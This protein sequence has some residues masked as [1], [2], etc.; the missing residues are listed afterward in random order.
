MFLPALF[1]WT[2]VMLQ[3]SKVQK[4]HTLL[5]TISIPGLKKLVHGMPWVQGEF[6]VVFAGTI[7]SE[8]YG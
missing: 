1:E 8:S 6:W 2:N 4:I 7:K 3:D 5:Y